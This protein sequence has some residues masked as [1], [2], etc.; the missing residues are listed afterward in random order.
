[1]VVVSLVCVLVVSNS[2]GVFGVDVIVAVLFNP[3][4]L[5]VVK[6]FGVLLLLSVP[7]LPGVG[8][9]V[10]LSAVVPVPVIPINN[11]INVFIFIYYNTVMYNGYFLTYQ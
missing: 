11:N 6:E 9:D 4:V 2:P 3:C 5:S 7:V 1:M 8:V 10:N